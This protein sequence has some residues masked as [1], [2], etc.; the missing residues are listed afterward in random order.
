MMEMAAAARAAASSLSLPVMVFKAGDDS[1]VDPRALDEFCARL[2][3]GRTVLFPD[4]RHE[5]LIE[6]DAVRNRAIEEIR[7]FI[8][9]HSA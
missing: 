6:T 8:A 7:A 1:Y 3:D 9:L 2:P 4:A 5:I